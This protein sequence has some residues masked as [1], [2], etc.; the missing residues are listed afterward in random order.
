[1]DM[2]ANIMRC[3]FSKTFSPNYN[4]DLHSYGQT[5]SLFLYDLKLR[6]FIGKGQ[7]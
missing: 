4:L 1:M 5:L 6:N 7:N 2:N 3:F